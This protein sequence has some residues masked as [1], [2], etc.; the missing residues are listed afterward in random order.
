MSLEDAEALR[1]LRD[2]FAPCDAGRPGDSGDLVHRFYT[3]W[4][5]LDP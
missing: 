2:A 4:F 3:H 5:A 1:V